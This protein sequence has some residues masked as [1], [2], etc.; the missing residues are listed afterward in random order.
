MFYCHEEVTY[1]N[2]VS[3]STIPDIPRGKIMYRILSSEIFST[4]TISEK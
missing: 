1:H 2:I 4:S 3:H